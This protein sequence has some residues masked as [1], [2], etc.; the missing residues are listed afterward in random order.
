MR[1]LLLLPLLPLPGR[2]GKAMAAGALRTPAHARSTALTGRPPF[3][4]A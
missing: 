1:M 3:R 4:L 2:V